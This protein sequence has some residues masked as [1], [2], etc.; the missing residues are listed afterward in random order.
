MMSHFKKF[1]SDFSNV[2]QGDWVKSATSKLKNISKNLEK[3]QDIN[4]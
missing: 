1:E 2:T 3:I 4:V